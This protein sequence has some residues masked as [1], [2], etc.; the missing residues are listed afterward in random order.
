MRRSP[1]PRSNTMSALGPLAAVSIAS[2]TSGGVA[3]KRTSG[4]WVCAAATRE[5]A[6]VETASGTNAATMSASFHTEAATIFAQSSADTEF[7]VPFLRTGGS[8]DLRDVRA[9]ARVRE[10]ATMPIVAL[11]AGTRSGSVRIARLDHESSQG[12][13]HSCSPSADRAPGWRR[14]VFA[15]RLRWQTRSVRDLGG[16]Q[17]RG[18]EHPAA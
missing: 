9:Y 15:A 6:P 8:I 5:T 17:Q 10:E 4:R 11:A 16:G 7:S 18:V 3:T 14:S 12:G 13:N 2:T 1:E